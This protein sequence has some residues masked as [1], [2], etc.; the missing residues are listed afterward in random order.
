MKYVIGWLKLRPGARDE[1]MT[2]ARP[3]VA[4]TLKE[5][6]MIFFEFHHNS[7]DPDGV[8]VVECYRDH[9]T[10]ERHWTTS[11]FKEMWAHV[12]RLTLEGH[13]ENVFAARIEPDH[14]RFADG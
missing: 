2:L 13:F 5:D 3:F 1:F 11:H 12:E 6:G 10:H 14:I 4:E 7:F 9:A 8:V